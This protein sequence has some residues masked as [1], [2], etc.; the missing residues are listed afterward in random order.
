[1]KYPI[2]CCFSNLSTIFFCSRYCKYES[3]KKKTY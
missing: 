1:M 3:E 2:N